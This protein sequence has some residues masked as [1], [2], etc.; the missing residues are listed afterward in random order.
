MSLGAFA[1]KNLNPI[2]FTTLVLGVL[3]AVAY[4]TFPVSILPDVTFPR[5]KIIADTGD[6]PANMVE[7][8][9]TRPI[10][11]AVATVPNVKNIKAKTQRG[12]T[13]MSV[14]FAWGT[15]ILVAEQLVNAKVNE[16]RSQLPSSTNT[17]VERMNPTI[18]PVLGLS[19]SSKS[20]SASELWNL[21][22]YRL[23]PRLSRIEGVA[24]VVIQGGRPPEVSVEVD[25]AKLASFK[26]S[27]S[28]VSAA[29]A[30]ANMV[31]SVGNLDER[32]RRYQILVD[33]LATAPEDLNSISVAQRGGT[34]VTLGQIAK[35]TRS[36]EDR[37]TVVVANGEE[38]VLLN[39]VRQPNANSVALVDAVNQELGQIRKSLP[40]RTHLDSFYDQS[41]IIRDAVQSVQEAV[42][43]GA[44]LAVVVLLLF[45]KDWRAT[46]VTA[47]IIPATV[48]ITFLLMRAAGLTLNLMTLGALAVGIG[49]V[50]D[51]AIVVV[52]NVVRGLASD[53][54]VAQVVQQATAE[55]AVPMI[56]STLTTVV[57]FLPLALLEGVAGAFFI[58]LALT[59]SI[60]LMVSL[61]LALLLSPSLCARF[62]KS[63]S[64]RAHG[65]MMTGLLHAYEVTMK[66]GL[67]RP[68][69]VPIVGIALLAVTAF[70]AGKLGTG[71]MPEMDE[72]A[73]VLD[74]YTP[75]GSSLEESD[76]LLKKVDEILKET[77]EIGTYSR[78]TGTELGFAITEAH[79]GDYAVM[80]KTHRHRS[81]DKVMDEIRDKI[82]NEVPGLDID[83]VQV[84]QD[85][86]GDLSG[87][88]API[89]VKL[90]GESRQ[91]VRAA[92]E[93]L[94]DKLGKI[95]G[96]VD[97]KSGV[98]ATGPEFTIAVDTIKAGRVGLTPTAVADQLTASVFGNVATSLLQEDR[99]VPVRVRF[100]LEYRQDADHLGTV[101]IQAPAGF[102]MPL[103]SLAQITETEGGI[104]LAREDQRRLM[105]VTAR[106]DG[107]DLGSAVRL[108]QKAVRE[109]PIAPGIEVELGGQFRSQSR[110]F[111]NLELVLGLAVVL[112]F[113][114]MLFQFRDFT[115]PAVIL[116]IM[117][118]ASFGA[119]TAL[120]LTKTALNVSSFMGMVM[121]AGIVVKNGILL[122]DRVKVAESEGA[123]TEEAI[124]D[125][126][127][128]RI[129][130]ILMTTLTALLGLAPL[131]LG[132]GAGAEM[133][134]PLAI[135][136]IGGLSVSTLL[137]LVMGP[138]LYAA[139]RTLGSRF[140]A[141]H[142][143]H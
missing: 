117:P 60:A 70:L 6:R 137:T 125:A 5:V 122:L 73:F 82:T 91:E 103:S 19:L 66:W 139:F 27:L 28:D 127:R 140:V 135:A 52:E 74:Y 44:V 29:L 64:E 3:G 115:A 20:L 21:A 143:R 114:V 78:R 130:P 102:N 9:V 99:Q 126:G 101:P 17:Q 39:I 13:E 32:R 100:P 15:D 113:A 77:P 131:A 33:G 88:P 43:T 45:L 97:I 136:V 106:L 86:I 110:A 94:A 72:G 22:T 36:V 128:L 93:R 75:P 24:R 69:A 133:Q 7:V 80:L 104:E 16:V 26:L 47:A 58:A 68:W 129:R 11:Q 76:R 10:E 120:Y 25:P 116:C 34:A 56:S 83:F 23:K 51:D 49:L 87:D 85:L 142:S 61:G 71:F 123:S 121:L 118:M 79:R 31:T 98:Y 124:L 59:L 18:F 55:I 57:V 119:V 111:A 4:G 105:G 107:I 53:N 141:P 90:F 95:K 92:A 89:E 96:L 30:A 132:L 67:K 134:K 109:T 138:L 65:R 54:P 14:D 1:A 108:V 37:N 42:L 8:S 38:C 46:I 12:S 48:L 35:V 63:H 2:L 112:V 40:S 81:I 62:L 50:I 84:L 41:V